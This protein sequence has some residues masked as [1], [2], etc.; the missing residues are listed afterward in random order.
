MLF[1]HHKNHHSLGR[2]IGIVKEV[3]ASE[4][5]GIIIDACFIDVGG[6]QPVVKPIARDE[7]EKHKT[8]P[9]LAK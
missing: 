3:A 6:G 4:V 7:I 8:E 5:A 1:F 2:I 9:A